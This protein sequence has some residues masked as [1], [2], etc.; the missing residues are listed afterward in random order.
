[1]PGIQ[2]LY[3][4]SFD[5]LTPEFW[6]EAFS[7]FEQKVM[8]E[9]R[10]PFEGRYIGGGCPPIEIPEGW[11]LIYHAVSGDDNGKHLYRAGIALLDKEDPTKVIGR[12]SCPFFSPQF[13]WEKEGVVPNVVFPTGAVIKDGRLL[14]YYGA[15]D[16]HIASC[17]VDVAQVV[18]E[19][20]EN[21]LAPTQTET[22]AEHIAKPWGEE[23]L[24][25]PPTL[26]RVGKVLSL[27]A[28]K[29]LSLQYHDR[30][31]ETILL[32]AGEAKIWLGKTKET[33]V[34]EPMRLNV[35][36][37][38]PAGQLHRLEAITDCEFFEVSS[39][40]AG[41]TYRIDDDFKRPNEQFPAKG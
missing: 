17:S 38:I 8:L 13:S 6:I 31:E 19:L 28:G 16:T 39:P 11:L 9:P 34:A 21:P 10:Y 29:R 37:T 41:T 27:K 2:V 3:F 5:Q 32:F 35:G 36:Y 12:L 33:V 14:I 1:M 15:A 40:E 4:D 26:S 7:R 23:I 20:L 25:T 18:T 24:F 22:Y 30:K